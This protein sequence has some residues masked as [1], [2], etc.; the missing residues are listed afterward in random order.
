MQY[1]PEVESAVS[2]GPRKRIAV[3]TGHA[4]LFARQQFSCELGYLTGKRSLTRTH[5]DTDQ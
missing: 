2:G 1:G 3:V 4:H 5:Q